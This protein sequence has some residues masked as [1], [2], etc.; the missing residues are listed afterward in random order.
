M[1]DAW[2]SIATWEHVSRDSCLMRFQMGPRMLV[3]ICGPIPVYRIGHWLIGLAVHYML[4]PTP[5]DPSC[6]QDSRLTLAL[7]FISRN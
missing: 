2:Y 1:S 4:L 3:S 6:C 7:M 5:G